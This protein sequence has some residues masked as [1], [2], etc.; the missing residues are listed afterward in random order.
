MK[1][2]RIAYEYLFLPTADLVYNGENISDISIFFIF[3]AIDKKTSRERY[4]YG[5][6][7]K[8]Q[9]LSYS[10]SKKC[11]MNNFYKCSV[12]TK[13]GYK[14]IL[15]EAINNESLYDVSYEI[16]ECSKTV[17]N[18]PIQISYTD[19]LDILLSNIENFYN[20]DNKSAQTTCCYFTEI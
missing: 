8:E 4:F 3:K 2:Y 19:F 14:M 6:E 13:S 20:N 11:Y 12:D 15:N 5:D 7:M 9:C 18:M 1:R 16:G 10:K 17:G